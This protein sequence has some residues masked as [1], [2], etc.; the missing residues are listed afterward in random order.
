DQELPDL[1][2][3]LAK[4]DAV[5]AAESVADLPSRAPRMVGVP[6]SENVS[7]HMRSNGAQ[8]S[9]ALRLAVRAGIGEPIKT[10]DDLRY[11]LRVFAAYAVNSLI[12]NRWDVLAERER[13]AAVSAH[14]AWKDQV[15]SALQGEVAA[16]K[17]AEHL[18]DAEFKF[19]LELVDSD[20]AGMAQNLAGPKVDVPALVAGRSL[21]WR[22]LAD[23][24][25]EACGSRG[26]VT[27][28]TGKDAAGWASYSLTVEP[29]A[30][31]V[32]SVYVDQQWVPL[33]AS[34]AGTE[35]ALADRE[36]VM[37]QRSQ[38]AKPAPYLGSVFPDKLRALV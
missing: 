32:L 22:A 36:Q 29:R 12:G 6:A 23:E 13:V 34:A 27:L 11:A 19:V 35:R 21:N 17:A 8:L 25:A 1:A 30:G 4:A 5:V 37:L 28:D 33:E 18:T 16:I 20:R 3:L 9:D 26:N 10:P 2:D 31:W 15:L 14:D 24:W 38:A 7:G